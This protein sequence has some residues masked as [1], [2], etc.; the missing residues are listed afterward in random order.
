[1]SSRLA[2]DLTAWIRD[3]PHEA[4]LASTLYGFIPDETYDAFEAR[5][6]KAGYTE[7]L[8]LIDIL[9]YEAVYFGVGCQAFPDA[10][11]PWEGNDL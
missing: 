10:V 6:L 8:A 9:G 7:V 4:A 1:M 3:H 11:D 2:P 5:L